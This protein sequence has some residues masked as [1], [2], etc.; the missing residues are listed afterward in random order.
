MEWSGA[1]HAPERKNVLIVSESGAWL[2]DPAP[3]PSPVWR[4]TAGQL[5]AN[6]TW[7]GAEYVLYNDLSGDTHLLGADAVELLLLLQQGGA[8]E[9][10]LATALTA[11]RGDAESTLATADVAALLAQLST[12]SLVEQRPC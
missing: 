7:D 3:A 2:A 11:V 8:D 5:I 6:R 9:Q 4:L 10:A 12:L 1:R